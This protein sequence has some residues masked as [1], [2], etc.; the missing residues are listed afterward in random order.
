[1]IDK[2][3][4]ETI[5]KIIPSTDKEAWVKY[6]KQN[7]A[8]QTSRLLD[9]QGITWYPFEIKG[10]TKTSLSASSLNNNPINNDREIF[11]TTDIE[12]K[13]IRDKVDVVVHKG[14]IVEQI[15][16]TES[17]TGDIV[18]K[19]ELNGAIQLI[20]HSFIAWNFEKFCGIVSF[21]YVE[22]IILAVRIRP[23]EKCKEFYPDHVLRGMNSLYTRRRWTSKVDA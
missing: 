19:S 6:P 1:M 10:L 12:L 9:F 18:K 14:K 13:D 16:Y 7:W 4:V 2:H 17:S 8:Y 20:L 23:H 5:G 21:E 15:Y 22:N 3:T 11:I